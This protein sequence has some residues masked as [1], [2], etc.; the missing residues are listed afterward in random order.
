MTTGGVRRFARELGTA[1]WVVL[2]L[3]GPA[4]ADVSTASDVSPVSEVSPASEVSSVSDATMEAI[5]VTGGRRAGSRA[6]ADQVTITADT[7]AA[8]RASNL[9]DILADAPAAAVQTNSRGETLVYLRGAG[10]RQTALFFASAPINVPWDN[11]LDLTLVPAGAASQVHLTSGPAS[12]LFGPNTA[13]GVIELSA[14][15]LS[16]DFEAASA[17]RGGTGGLVE[18]TALAA[19]D[20]GPVDGVFAGGWLR[21]DGQP[22]SRRAGLTVAQD[23]H[24]LRTNTDLRRTNS[25]IRLGMDPGGPVRLSANLLA[26]D[27]AFGIAPEGRPDP[28]GGAPRFWRYPG[29]THVV[30]VLNGAYDDGGAR[31]LNVA[32]WGQI[33][34]QTIESFASAGFADL[35]DRQRDRDRTHGLRTVAARHWADHTVRGAFSMMDAVHRQT[36]EAL[37]DGL[38]TDT[39]E[40]RFRRRIFSLGADYEG[41]WR[42]LSLLIGAGGDFVQSLETGGRASGDGFSAWSLVGGLD[43]RLGGAWAVTFSAARKARLPTPRE[44]YGEAIDRFV[45]NPDLR[46]ERSVQVEAA[47]RFEGEGV[48]FAVTPFATFASGTIDQE[49]VQVDGQSFRRRINLEGSRAFGVDVTGEVHVTPSLVL[50]GALSA[51]HLRRRGEDTGSGHRFI[52]ER[53]DLIGVLTADY[54]HG[55]GIG[56]RVDLRHRGRAYTPSTDGVLPLPRA[57]T[58]DVD[59]SYRREGAAGAMELF[60]RGENLSDALVEPQFGL[61]APGRMVSAGLR[62]STGTFP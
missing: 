47:L 54:R 43:Y 51:L 32:A 16:A 45:L 15:A 38:V 14:P 4:R 8:R 12:V 40:A 21:R 18:A 20:V 26:V 52:A 19:G 34:R 22:L 7:I 2:G 23:G 41:H 29:T 59:L 17:W 42:D 33:F 49:T 5:I 46:P 28:N 27:S 3:F 9:G 11:R 24:G 50:S 55:S 10:E 53:P 60:V 30:G 56:L 6:S 37:S 61:P 1:A 35:E 48:S 25:L 39:E 44:L 62:L 13:G 31:E 58:V 57:T 36:D